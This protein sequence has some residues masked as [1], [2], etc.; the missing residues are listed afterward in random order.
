[1]CSLLGSILHTAA[2][3]EKHPFTPP[4]PPKLNK[5]N[6][7]VKVR[8]QPTMKGIIS[9]KCV[10]QKNSKQSQSFRHILQIKSDQ[11]QR[12]GAKEARK[13]P[14]RSVLAFGFCISSCKYSMSLTV[15]DCNKVKVTKADRAGSNQVA[16]EAFVSTVLSEMLQAESRGHRSVSDRSQ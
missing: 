5:G 11:C 12:E 2:Q 14:I 15:N 1:M 16:D 7:S 4:Q 10:W 13:K 8:S 3:L 9:G 6:G